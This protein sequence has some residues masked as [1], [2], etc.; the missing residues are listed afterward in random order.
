[1]KFFNFHDNIKKR[2]N[3]RPYY[4]GT[5]EPIIADTY[6]LP[7]F[8]FS[9]GGFN[10]SQVIN[11]ATTDITSYFD[12]GTIDIHNG[13]ITYNGG[14]LTTP[15]QAGRCYFLGGSDY[16][17]DDCDVMSG[18]DYLGSSL[19]GSD[20]L[21]SGI[22]DLTEDLITIKVSSTVDFGGTYYKG[23]F[24]QLMAKRGVISRAPKANVT[25][26]GDEKNGQIIKE[27]IV[28]ASKFTAV[29]KVTES[30][31]EGLL[32]AMPGDWTMYDRGRTYNCEKIEIEDPDWYQGNGI[33]RINFED[34]ISVFT[35][36]N[37]DL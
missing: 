20:Y 34:N 17:T 29:I 12:A 16:Y 9:Y 33:C 22:D 13:I 8:Q 30:E 25:I 15:V 23:G 37:A 31:F 4:R 2:V 10:V 28:T 3:Y 19:S 24:F 21:P 18:S 27:K 5:W 14:M 32:E 11:G 26:T 6:H 36:N 1:M 7:P 35:Y